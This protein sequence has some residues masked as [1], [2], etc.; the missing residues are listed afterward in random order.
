MVYLLRGRANVQ[1][2]TFSTDQEAT[3][4]RVLRLVAQPANPGRSVKPDST[5]REATEPNDP[6]LPGARQWRDAMRG[7][8]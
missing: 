6:S 2:T 4:V 7:A 1:P 8:C 5:S 3:Q